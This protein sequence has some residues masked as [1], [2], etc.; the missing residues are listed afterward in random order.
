M[1]MSAIGNH[2]QFLQYA[3]KNDMS[4]ATEAVVQDKLEATY[5]I[6]FADA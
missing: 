2:P 1:N 4:I 5:F 6:I 3:M